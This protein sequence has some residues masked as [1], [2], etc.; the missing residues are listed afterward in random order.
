[1]FTT[2]VLRS[3]ATGRYY[4]GSTSD[5]ARRLCEHNEDISTSTKNHGPWELIHRE[6]FCTLSEAVRRERYFKTGKGR[7]E[8][9]RI[10]ADSHRSSAG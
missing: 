7:D 5:L 6:D 1:M 9:R 4:T 3:K 2:Y 10:L 8:L